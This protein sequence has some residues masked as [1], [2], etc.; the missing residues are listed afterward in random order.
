M[1]GKPD[2]ANVLLNMIHLAYAAQDEQT[3]INDVFAE[4][5]KLV[6]FSSGVC[7]PVNPLTMELQAG[8]CFDC[9][10]ADMARYLAHYAAMDPFVL[11]PP[12]P[13]LFNRNLLL[14]DVIS[15]SELARSEYSE[16]LRRVPYQHAMGMLAGHGERPVAAISV[17]RMRHEKDFG[18]EEK[19]IFEYMVPHLARAMILRDLAS[20][21]LLR[22][23]VGLAV[24]RVEGKVLY[25]NEQARRYLGTT[26]SSALWAELSRQAEGVI[27]LG[28]HSLRFSRLPWSAASLLRHFAGVHAMAQVASPL[29]HAGV[30]HAGGAA[31][32]L[33]DAGASILVLRPL[34]PRTDLQRRLA[35]Y[36]LSPRQCE[37]AIWALRG[38]VNREIAAEMNISEQTVRDHFQEVYE[39]IGVH[40][41]SEMMAK[42]LGTATGEHPVERR[43]GARFAGKG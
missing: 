13:T 35:K 20:N 14:S 42:V 8:P 32:P 30:C 26:P 27:R 24:L 28:G 4:M 23:E 15:P 29:D 22:V 6:S 25:A 7:M 3:M 11:R 2:T 16:F 40:S 17:H 1:L 37:I 19:A 41:R 21:S 38:L 10:P 31:R 12:G 39:H 5:R 34:L 9:F 33:V 18:K 43:R 36:G